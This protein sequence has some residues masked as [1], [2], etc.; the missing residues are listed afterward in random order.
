MKKITHKDRVLQYIRDFGSIT[1]YE[2]FRE[3]GVTRLSAVI[4][5]LK[6]LGYEFKT[7]NEHSKNRYGDKVVFSRYYLVEENN[8]SQITCD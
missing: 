4:F 2:A 3:L 6:K 5:S 1:S 8:G 7:E